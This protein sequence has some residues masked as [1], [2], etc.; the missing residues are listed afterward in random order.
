MSSPLFY[1]P[2][3]KGGIIN[4]DP[5]APPKSTVGAAERS[6]LYQL[7]MFKASMDRNIIVVV[8]L[9][10]TY[11]SIILILKTDGYW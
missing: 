3:L 5:M 8:V 11:L 10:S 7:E 4:S 9:H 1:N 6:R 2:A